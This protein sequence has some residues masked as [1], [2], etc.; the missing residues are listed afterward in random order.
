MMVGAV[1]FHTQTPL[2]IEV[3]HEGKSDGGSLFRAAVSILVI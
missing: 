3:I 2:G 1:F